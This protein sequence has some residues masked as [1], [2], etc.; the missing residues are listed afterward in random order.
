MSA[1]PNQD[2]DVTV[3]YSVIGGTALAD[4]DYDYVSST[5]RLVFLTWGIASSSSASRCSMTLILSRT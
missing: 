1:D 3:D 4:V 2:Q 5:G